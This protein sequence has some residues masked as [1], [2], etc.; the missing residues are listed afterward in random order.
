MS[1]IAWA[2]TKDKTLRKRNK[3]DNCLEV[4]GLNKMRCYAHPY[5]DQEAT[6]LRGYHI[7]SDFDRI[8]MESPLKSPSVT[9]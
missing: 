8:A 6:H 9:R 1:I 5:Y 2:V 3:T 4:G 7:G